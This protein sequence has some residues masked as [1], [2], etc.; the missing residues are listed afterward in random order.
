MI[1]NAKGTGF[2]TLHS[3]WKWDKNVQQISPMD[4]FMPNKSAFDLFYGGKNCFT[5]ITVPPEVEWPR[6]R[7]DRV[8]IVSSN[9]K[10]I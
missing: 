3:S 7:E 1:K 10:E 9:H 5:R 6:A 8:K 2:L 4:S